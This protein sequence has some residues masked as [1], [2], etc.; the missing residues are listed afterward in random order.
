MQSLGSRPVVAPLGQAQRKRKMATICL[1]SNTEIESRQMAG[2]QDFTDLIVDSSLRR[3]RSEAQTTTRDLRTQT[4]R[5]SSPRFCWLNRRLCQHS[6]HPRMEK[7]GLAIHNR[8]LWFP[9]GLLARGRR[10]TTPDS[11]VIGN[12]RL[13]IGSLFAHLPIQPLTSH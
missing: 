8:E 5:S 2:N 12:V 10:Q 1:T 11:V 3:S 9:D 4:P 7:T 6:K 13:A